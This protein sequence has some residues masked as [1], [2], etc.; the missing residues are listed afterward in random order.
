M[1]SRFIERFNRFTAWQSERASI[2][3]ALKE[4]IPRIL[5]KFPHVLETDAHRRDGGIF[6]RGLR[7]AYK[8]ALSSSIVPAMPN[9][10]YGNAR[11]FP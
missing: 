2:V 9:H 10:I 8:H 11:S 6:L 3:P 5:V 7:L 4:R 1:W